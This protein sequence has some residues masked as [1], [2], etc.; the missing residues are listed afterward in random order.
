[1]ANLDYA[2]SFI[3]FSK[4][5]AND[6]EE[7]KK[8][9]MV[10]EASTKQR[11]TLA[12]SEFNKFIIIFKLDGRNTIGNEAYEALCKEYFS[13]ITPYHSV[14][15]VDDDTNEEIAVLPPIFNSV[16]CV[17]NLGIVGSQAIDAFTNAHES[18]DEFNI[19]KKTYTDH[20]KKV[21]QAVQNNEKLEYNRQEVNRILEDLKNNN[22]VGSNNNSDIQP[23]VLEEISNLDSG[24]SDEVEYL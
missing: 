21:F 10:L 6:K 22:V 19:K 15:I 7:I 13:R 16:E 2:S 12:L 23:L 20:L 3:N 5:V 9:N 4:V 18:A 17:S 8:L 24:L 11:N 1:M 14:H